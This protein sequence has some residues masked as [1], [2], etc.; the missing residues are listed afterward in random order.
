MSLNLVSKKTFHFVTLHIHIYITDQQIDQPTAT[1]SYLC[2]LVRLK[3]N[4]VF[5]INSVCD[6]VCVGGGFDIECLNY[7]I[8]TMF[9]HQ[10]LMFVYV[11]YVFL[12]ATVFEC[13]LCF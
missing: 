3:K 8:D 7:D 10:I 9:F 13:S 4:Q 6:S 2:T 11:F 12:K 1:A 5:Y